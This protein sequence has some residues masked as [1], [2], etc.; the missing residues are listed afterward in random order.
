VGGPP[1][2]VI[3]CTFIVSVVVSVPFATSQP[4][5]LSESALLVT[6]IIFGMYADTVHVSTSIPTM[7]IYPFQIRIATT[8]NYLMQMS[9]EPYLYLNILLF[10]I[11]RIL[12]EIKK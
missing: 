10:K 2:T 12:D 5:W 9:N 8:P 3:F 11:K 6:V 4:V 1:P 7:K